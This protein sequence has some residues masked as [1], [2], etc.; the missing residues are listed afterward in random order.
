MTVFNFSVNDNSPDGNPVGYAQAYRL[1]KGLRRDGA[2]RINPVGPFPTTYA[3]TGDPVT[4]TGWV[5][6]LQNDQ[7]FMMST[8]PVNVSPGD[9]Q[10][11]VIAQII[12]RGTSNLNSITFLRQY[13]S[14][15]Q[16]YSYGCYSNPAIGIENNNELA[17]D[18]RLYQNY[19]NPFNPATK[20]KFDVPSN[21]TLSDAKGLI[22]VLT[23]YDVLGRE[24]AVLV[25]DKLS[26]GTYEAE[27]DATNYPSGVY[28]Y[29]LTAGDYTETRRMVLI[30]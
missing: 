26:P 13:S 25:N 5:Q 20:I 1:M 4:N 21:L 30:K 10:V 7:R 16:Q 27:W 17:N 8:G 11:I 14:T 22:V 29:K 15:A 2:V 6:S 9:T 18:F 3:F 19:P 28:L 24:A 12:A 23:I